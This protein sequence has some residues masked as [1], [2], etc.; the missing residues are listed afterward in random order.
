LQSL[1][2][3]MQ[4]SF[5][6]YQPMPSQRDFPVPRPFEPPQIEP[7]D[8]D[9]I[10]P[11]PGTGGGGGGGGGGNGGGGGGGG[12][13]Q[14]PANPWLQLT[15]TNAMTLASP[16][17]GPQLEWGNPVLG[18]LPA[19]PQFSSVPQHDGTIQGL[20]GVLGNQSGSGGGTGTKGNDPLITTPDGIQMTQSQWDAYQAKKY[21]PSDSYGTRGK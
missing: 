17:S 13:T 2:Q 1:S 21:V 20:L 9:R 19:V 3:M 8:D 5:P 6:T 15:P 7:I 10:F 18:Q 4:P 14:Q 12:V 16:H 11:L